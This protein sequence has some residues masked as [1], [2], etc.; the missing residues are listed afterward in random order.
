[1]TK[2]TGRSAGDRFEE[3]KQVWQ[4]MWRSK[5]H[6]KTLKKSSH[7]KDKKIRHLIF[8]DKVLCHSQ[9]A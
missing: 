1:M 4:S 9:K 2:C 8:M 7:M 5:I 3:Q 6:M